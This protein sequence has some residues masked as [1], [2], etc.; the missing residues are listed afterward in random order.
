MVRL[1]L[2]VEYD[3]SG[4]AGWQSQAHGNTVQDVLEKALA[5]VAGRPLRVACAGRT[6]AGVH[7]L[8]Q[9]VHFDCDVVRP[10]TAW[11][12]GVNAHLPPPVAVRWAREVGPEFHARFL[13]RSRSYRY[14]L[15][16]RA[17][18]PALL[19]G[20]V[21]WFHHPL[22]LGAMRE[23]AACLIGEHDFSAFRAAECQAKSPVKHLYR[24]D[25][26]AQGDCIVFDFRANAFLHHMIRN[27][28]GSLVYIGKG[29][30]APGWLAELLEARDRTR[31]APTFAA[32][33]LYFAGAE[34]DPVW[35]LPETGR[36]ITDSILPVMP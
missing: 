30:H 19:A 3:G 25:I 10:E 20:R 16:N 8:C 5:A 1:A 17:V 2:G 18:R 31:A 23:A 12:R 34:Y 28:V 4:F 35:Q 36:I 15:L 26:E 11:V 14:V 7:A 24:A 32:D 29:K 22:D 33:G 27:I 9:F 6:D 21:G 13:A